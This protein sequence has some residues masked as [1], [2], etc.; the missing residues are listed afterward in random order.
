MEGL[1]EPC[2][3]SQVA[4]LRQQLAAAKAEVAAL[5]RALQSRDGGVGVGGATAA[6][7]AAVAAEEAHVRTCAA[8]VEAARLRLHLVRSVPKRS[9]VRMCSMRHRVWWS[10]TMRS[11]GAGLGV[12]T[13]TMMS[14]CSSRSTF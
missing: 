2:E 6:A 3:N 4:V 14:L 12:W 10:T 9:V 13:A 11:G 8:E 1:L 5:R 7:A